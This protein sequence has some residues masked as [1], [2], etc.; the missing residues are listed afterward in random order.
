MRITYEIGNPGFSGAPRVSVPRISPGMS[1]SVSPGNAPLSWKVS[2]AIPGDFPY[3]SVTERIVRTRWYSRD[4]LVCTAKCSPGDPEPY[5]SDEQSWA[6]RVEYRT[7]GGRTL[8][9]QFLRFD[10]G[11]LEAF[12]YS[13]TSDEDNLLV[14]AAG[15]LCDILNCGEPERKVSLLEHLLIVSANIFWQVHNDPYQACMHEDD[16][17]VSR[18]MAS[19]KAAVSGGEPVA[20]M[21]SVR[22]HLDTWF[23]EGIPPE[24]FRCVEYVQ[25]RFDINGELMARLERMVA[26]LDFRE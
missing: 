9:V 19:I 3:V 4:D 22:L 18:R 25:E 20:R 11:G 14:S 5:V 21:H 15:N 8:M 7:P 26:D 17:T 24:M 12:R 23:L 2:G 1:K 10:S 16:V 13:G 6:R